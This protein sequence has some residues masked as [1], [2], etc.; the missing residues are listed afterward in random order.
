MAR[1]LC[2]APNDVHV[3]DPIIFTLLQ[4]TLEIP[5][6]QHPTVTKIWTTRL[7]RYC[8]NQAHQDLLPQLPALWSQHAKMKRYLSLHCRCVFAVVSDWWRR[9]IVLAAAVT[10]LT[11]LVGVSRLPFSSICS[12]S[13]SLKISIFFFT[14]CISPQL[15]LTGCDTVSPAGSGT[16]GGVRCGASYHS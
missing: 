7:R 5:H 3:E 10:A 8:W 15:F 11:A 16:P 9:S 1:G 12:I 6:F 4:R 13:M 14:A 2:R